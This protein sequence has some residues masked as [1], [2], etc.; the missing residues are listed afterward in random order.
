MFDTVTTIF[1][2]VVRILTFQPG[3]PAPYRHRKTV[4]N[5]SDTERMR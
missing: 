4:V 5:P 1:M 2:D 3:R